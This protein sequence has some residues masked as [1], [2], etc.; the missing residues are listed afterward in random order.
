MQLLILMVSRGKS[1]FIVHSLFTMIKCVSLNLRAASV[2]KDIVETIVLSD[3]IN[4]KGNV[5]NLLFLVSIKKL[6]S[7]L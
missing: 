5:V 6:P 4:L 7:S 3:Y 1:L 2:W